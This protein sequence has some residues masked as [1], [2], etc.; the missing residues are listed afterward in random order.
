[1]G[2]KVRISKAAAALLLAAEE[3]RRCPEDDAEW[4]ADSSPPTLR[5]GVEENQSDLSPLDWEPES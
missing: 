2:D 3:L 5:S 4:L 1:M